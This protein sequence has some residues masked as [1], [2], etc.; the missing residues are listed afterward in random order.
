MPIPLQPSIPAQHIIMTDAERYE[1]LN[2]HKEWTRIW[3]QVNRFAAF[4][5]T[6][7]VLGEQASD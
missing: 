2:S 3:V 6:G 4:F 5:Y 1:A 7:S